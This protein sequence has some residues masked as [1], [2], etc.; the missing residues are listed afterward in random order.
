MPRFDERT[1]NGMG[2]LAAIVKSGSFAA[3]G[4]RLDMSQPGVSRAVARLEAR[5]GVRLLDRTTRSVT[6]TDEGRRLYEQV[7]P[8]L[9]ALEEAATSATQ[10]ATAVRGRLRANIDP[11]FSQLVL[12]PQLGAFVEQYPELRVELVTRDQLGDMVADGFDLAVRFGVP[13]TSS[14]VA[15][16]L[17]ETRILTVAAPSYLKRRARPVHPNDLQGETHACIRFRDPDTGRPFDWEFHRGRKKIVVEAAGR[18]TVND[19]RTMHGVCMAGHGIAQVMELGVEP[20]LA[21]GRLVDLFPDWPDDRFPLYA[22]YPSR[23]HVP[24]KVRAFLDFIV[25]LAKPQPKRGERKKRS[26][27]A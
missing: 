27:T 17:L 15:R 8:L 18:L 16:K 3:A 25:A 4:E 21:D 1:L 26:G 7:M 19:V 20:Y 10:G 13:R 5:L 6:L 9:D 12:A 11:F 2:V 14:L 22:Y 24:A 23:H